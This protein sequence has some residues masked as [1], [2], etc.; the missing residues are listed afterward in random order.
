VSNPTRV[1]DWI[2]T[3][4]GRQFWPLDPRV[5]DVHLEDIAH[6]LSNVCRYTG[7]VREFYSVAEHSVHVSWS[8]EPE[9][10]LWGLLHDASEA[11][12]ADMARPVKQNMPVYVAAERLVMRAICERF[13]LDPVEPPSV[14]VADNVLLFTEKRD[15][16]SECVVPW[17]WSVEP[18][19]YVIE[20]WSPK[21]A[22]RRFLE[23]FTELTSVA[24]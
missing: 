15:L 1:G 7:H 6:A 10:A 2:Q 5:E 22:K 17:C 3:Y 13:G 11:Y 23:R 12:L 18:L 14:K 24:P 16:M 8:C 20:P 19:A 21:E 9:D 4:S